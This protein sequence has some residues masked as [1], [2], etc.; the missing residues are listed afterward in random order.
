M[1]IT[2]GRTPKPK[3]FEYRPRYYN[4]DEEKKKRRKR[5]LKISSDDTKYARKEDLHAQWRSSSIRSKKHKSSINIW[6]F[7]LIATILTF[8]IFVVI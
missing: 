3:S 7:L 5:E 8:I 1:K 4:P 6:V 2:F